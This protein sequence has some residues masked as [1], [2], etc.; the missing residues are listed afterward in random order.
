MPLQTTTPEIAR[1]LV[2]STGHVPAHLANSEHLGL[3]RDEFFL[4]VDK[5][6]CGWTVYTDIESVMDFIEDTER[7]HWFKE[8][9]LV[10]LTHNCDRVQFDAHANELKGLRTYEW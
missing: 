2:L 10:A 3:Q 1:T 6:E 9:L 7:T 8:V 4:A 5:Q